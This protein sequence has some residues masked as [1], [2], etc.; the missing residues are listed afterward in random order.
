MALREFGLEINEIKTSVSQS[1]ALRDDR[2][3]RQL[4]K[5]LTGYQGEVTQLFEIF[6]ETFGIAE[7]LKSDAPVRFLLRWGDRNH[8]FEKH[9]DILENFF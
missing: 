1:S 6:E 4:T 2:W 3:P 8:L 5:L 7:H 9:W